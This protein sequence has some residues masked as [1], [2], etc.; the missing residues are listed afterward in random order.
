MYHGNDGLL[1]KM[2][3]VPLLAANPS[4]MLLAGSAFSFLATNA[5]N[6]QE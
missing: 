1:M 6:F 5:R 4:I 2:I 3:M